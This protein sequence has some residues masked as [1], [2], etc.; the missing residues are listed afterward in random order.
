[1]N[2]GAGDVATVGYARMRGWQPVRYRRPRFPGKKS[3]GSSLSARPRFGMRVRR[4]GPTMT[5][6]KRSKK[7]F[8]KGK[9]TGDNS[10]LSYF[11][12][13]RS[14]M[15]RYTRLLYKKVQGRQ[16]DI[17]DRSGSK[18]S[19]QG[20][21]TNLTFDSLTLSDLNKIKIN[22]NGG[23]DTENDVKCFIGHVK[24]TM[25]IKNQSN[26]VAVLRFYDLLVK[27]TPISTTIDDP[28]EAW[29]K[30][31]LDGGITSFASTVGAT[32]F[33]SAEFRRYFDVKK[34]SV[35]NLEPGQE[36]VHTVIHRV[37]RIVSST[38]F[39]NANLFH[40]QGLTSFTLVM[41]HG[42]LGH[43]STTPGN[44]QIMSVRLDWHERREIKYGHIQENAPTYTYTS[45]LPGTITNFDFMGENQDVDLDDAAA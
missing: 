13:G 31:Y 29:N 5:R 30:G 43:E 23:V 11:H 17:T 33:E 25:R 7:L 42:T 6:T 9:K 8:Q 39:A 18:L 10:S 12:M 19:V 44:V 2:R 15:S 16:V 32:P 40:W 37:N 34:V 38:E 22:C 28:I 21:Q 36:H 41:Y 20:Q 27:R 45:T 26:S 4:R 24:R 1:M 14:W 3:L 35:M